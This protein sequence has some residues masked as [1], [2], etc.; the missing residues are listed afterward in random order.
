MG[1]G[2][3]VDTAGAGGNGENQEVGTTGQNTLAPE[4]SVEQPA[5]ED[6]GKPSLLDAVR[7]LYEK[8]KAAAAKLFG[9]KYFDVAETPGLMKALGLTGDKFTVRYGVISRHWG[10]DSDHNIPIEAWEQ[11]P[12]ALQHPFAITKYYDSLADKKADKIKGYKLYT[13]IKLNDGYIVVGAKVKSTGRDMEVNSIATVFSRDKVS[14]LEKEVYR[15]EKITPEQASLL[16]RSDSHQYPPAQ[17]SDASGANVNTNPDTTN[18]NTDNTPQNAPE[19]TT[20]EDG[21]AIVQAAKEERAKYKTRE[22]YEAAKEKEYAEHKSGKKNGIYTVVGGIKDVKTGKVRERYIT[23]NEFKDGVLRSSVT[24]DENGNKYIEEYYNERGQKTGTWRTY[25]ENGNI[26][27]ETRYNN[28]G[29]RDGTSRI[30]L[31][32]GTLFEEEN[33]KDGIRDGFTRVYRDG[34]VSEELLYTDGGKRRIVREWDENGKLEKNEVQVYT[35]DAFRREGWATV[36]GKV[37]ADNGLFMQVQEDG[38]NGFT[39]TRYD[40]RTGKVENIRS[41]DSAENPVES[42]FY[43]ANGQ[44]HWHVYYD[45]YGAEVTDL[46]TDGELTDRVRKLKLKN[47]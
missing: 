27:L 7:T 9:M 16:N 4:Q 10:K 44:L 25:H 46:Y 29:K 32:D 8:G 14:K 35:P 40:K 18:T 31:S 11:L 38:E 22:E 6:G 5:Q 34:R 30:F 33:Y 23:R 19:G 45:K 41:F 1:D 26:R 20:Q 15:G 17:E 24:Y 39:L 2:E 37:V 3:T 36:K 47:G 13:T 43:D 28:E 42:K 12:E 21:A